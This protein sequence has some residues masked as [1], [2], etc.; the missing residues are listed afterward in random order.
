MSDKRISDFQ[1]G[2]R[3]E[4]VVLI[5]PV[6]TVG[7][8][9]EEIIEQG[10]GI[11]YSIYSDVVE[12]AHY[13]GNL[14][15]VGCVQCN[16]HTVTPDA[17]FPQHF[18]PCGGTLKIRSIPN[19]GKY[20][21]LHIS[22]QQRETLITCSNPECEMILG[23]S[24]TIDR[25]ENYLFFLMLKQ[26]I[27]SINTGNYVDC[28]QRELDPD[29]DKGEVDDVVAR[30]GEIK[31]LGLISVA[32][33]ILNGRMNNYKYFLPAAL[34]YYSLGFTLVRGVDTLDG[35]DGLDE[36]LKHLF[37]KQLDRL[38]SQHASLLPFLIGPKSA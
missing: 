4:R 37:I 11:W 16:N 34:D 17:G 38:K 25:L 18:I 5:Q 7:Y 31:S 23:T 26:M 36:W 30:I 3:D 35:C 20:H 32:S 6:Q 19:S 1:Y 14:S 2:Q 29:H 10:D 22:N 33:E 9:K 21:F 13:P 27:P 12:N 8:S 15:H 24:L 28:N